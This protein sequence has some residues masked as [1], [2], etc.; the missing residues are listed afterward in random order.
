MEMGFSYGAHSHLINSV[1]WL[2]LQVLAAFVCVFCVFICV[3]YVVVCVF[4]ASI[5]V[6][7]VFLFA[8][9]FLMRV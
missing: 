1:S 5:C 4:H 6:S 7:H 8:N 2:Y 9:A 3:C